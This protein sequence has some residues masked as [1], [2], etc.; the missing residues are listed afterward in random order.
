MKT[1]IA[2]FIAV[3]LASGSHGFD[4]DFDDDDDDGKSKL[5]LLNITFNR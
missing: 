1:I 3:L 5:T 2:I 4:D